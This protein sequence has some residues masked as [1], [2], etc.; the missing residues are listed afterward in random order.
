MSSFAD[1]GVIRKKLGGATA[2]THADDDGPI[3]GN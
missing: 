1:V 3:G 2:V